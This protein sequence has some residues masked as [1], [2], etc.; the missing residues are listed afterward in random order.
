MNWEYSLQSSVQVKEQVWEGT[1]MGKRVETDMFVGYIGRYRYSTVGF[2][3]SYIYS[4][5]EDI[6][7]LR[8]GLK[9][10]F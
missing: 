3:Y 10:I 5:L 4:S 8:Y 2:I 6:F 9:N 1:G 7:G